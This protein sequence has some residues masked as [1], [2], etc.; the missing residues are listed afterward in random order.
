M[1]VADEA[2]RRPA[3][4]LT[5]FMSPQEAAGYANAFVLDP[6]AF[7]AQ[8]QQ[9]QTTTPRPLP[10][11]YTPPTVTQL[12]AAA[13]AHVT[14]VQGHQL[15][16]QVYQ[17]PH[18]IKMVELGKLIACQTWVDTHVSGSLHGASM[19]ATPTFDEILNTCLPLSVIPPTQIRAQPM[20]NG[21]IFYS[22]NNTLTAQGP[23]FNP[24]TGQ[25]TLAVAPAA[26]LML[27]RE[28]AG[29]YVL[30]N[31]YHRAWLLRSRAVSMVPAVVVPVAS[32]Q[33]VLP[34]PEGFFKPGLL[35]GPRPPI[36]DDFFD[37]TLS[38]SLH[39]VRCSSL[40]A[41]R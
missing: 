41:K 10:P 17:P 26:N 8:W 25:I 31:G 15:F 14:A 20:P 12:P 37:A 40:S 32:Q 35:F 7:L 39:M 27:V 5:G 24:A 1:P 18:E 3:R 19:Q 33:D 6:Q 21:W 28:Q 4:V 23:G 22:M 11:S 34:G 30:A 13:M 29:R 36:I 9:Q 2:V 16:G 38:A